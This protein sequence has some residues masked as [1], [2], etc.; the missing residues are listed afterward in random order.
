MELPA[1]EEYFDNFGCCRT[2]TKCRK[3]GISST[4]TPYFRSNHNSYI[5]IHLTHLYLTLTLI[6]GLNSNLDR[7]SVEI[8]FISIELSTHFWWLST[9]WRFG[10]LTFIPIWTPNQFFG[11]STSCCFGP[12][13]LTQGRPLSVLSTIHFLPWTPSLFPADFDF[14]TAHHVMW[15]SST[16]SLLDR[17]VEPSCHGTLRLM[18]RPLWPE[19]S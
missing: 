18:E 16:F 19:L 8:P 11:P 9:F 14:E 5:K 7:Q 6:W 13:T 4:H 17:P 10:P 1:L 3:H 15:R 2:Q 12:L